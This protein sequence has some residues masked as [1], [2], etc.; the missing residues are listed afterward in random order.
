MPST[1]RRDALIAGAGVASTVLA[2]CSDDGGS[3]SPA[4][5]G[6]IGVA[7]LAFTA[8]RPAGF[9]DYDP[10]P[11]ATYA[12]DE[13][14]WLYVE[15]SGLAGEPVEDETDSSMV[16]IELVQTVT[17]EAPDGSVLVDATDR[18]EPTLAARQL[19]SFFVGTDVVLDGSVSTGEYTV[20]LAYADRVSD[21]E[22]TETATF[23]IED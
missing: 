5:R 7:E 18:F 17:V 4:D 14:I 1:T 23:R 19:D 20:T 13:R 21:S 2:G 3:S 11:G 9:D 16:E 8:E 15:L 22:T 10:Q 6:P 12:A